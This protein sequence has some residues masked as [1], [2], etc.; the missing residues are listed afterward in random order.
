MIAFSSAKVTS[1]G[2]FVDCSN[3]IYLDYSSRSSINKKKN[4]DMII[5]TIY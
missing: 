3:L 1:A 4:N 5:H 2:Y